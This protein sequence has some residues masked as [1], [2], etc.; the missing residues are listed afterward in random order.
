MRG[1]RHLVVPDTQI[2]EGVSLEH[3]EWLAKYIVEKRPDVLVIIGDWADMPSLSHYDKNKKSS[4][5]RT[6]SGD[7][8]AANDGLQRLMAPIQAEI[9]KRERNHKHRWNL[10]KVVTLGN[11]EDRINRLVEE[12]RKLEGKVSTDDL[13][14]KQWGFEVYPF[15]E[16]VVIDGVAYC[17]YF[18]SGVKGL[19][20]N[21]ARAILSKHHMSCFAG[22]QQ[23][24]DIAYG[25]RADGTRITAIIAGSF[26]LHDEPYM[27]PQGNKHWRGIYMLHEVKDGAFDEMPV[28]IGFLKERYG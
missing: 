10:R 14:F 3:I 8:L 17:H 5:G 16:V 25:K 12:D 23:G 9:E 28:S 22:H 20:C 15:R 4:E 19:P 26:Y 21:S 6:Y 13:F 1:K 7:I 18:S 2:K 24:N 11:H 27:G